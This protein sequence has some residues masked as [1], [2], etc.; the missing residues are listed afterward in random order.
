[1]LLLLLLIFY[2]HYYHILIGKS[3][4]LGLAIAACLEL[5]YS[6]IFLTSPHPSNV[7]TVFEFVLSGL[8][9]LQYKEHL[10]YSILEMN[11]NNNSNNSNNDGYYNSNSNNN[12]SGDRNSNTKCVVRI[13]VFRNHRQTV[14]FVYPKHSERISQ[15]ICFMM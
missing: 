1:M 13:N 12:N 4:S 3:A 6:N 10:E 7:A 14:Q 5:G 8:A 11:N 2:Y 15:V 9:S